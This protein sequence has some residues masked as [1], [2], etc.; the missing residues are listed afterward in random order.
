MEWKNIS[1]G[2]D[3]FLSDEHGCS[4]KVEGKKGH[5]FLFPS[6]CLFFPSKYRL[7]SLFSFFFLFFW[8][9]VSYLSSH[10][11]S[12]S[13]RLSDICLI[14]VSLPIS[15]QSSSFIS[16][17]QLG[18]KW[19]FTL[20]AGIILLSHFFLSVFSVFWDESWSS[21]CLLPPCCGSS[22]WEH[23]VFGFIWFG[24]KICRGWK[25]ESLASGLINTR[26]IW[27]RKPL[28]TKQVL[29]AP[30]HVSL[31]ERRC[32]RQKGMAVGDHRT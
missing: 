4:L 14:L 16:V 17:A 26:G 32:S 23:R 5:V 31:L 3:E 11:Y 30:R 20:F 18:G 6:Y 22:S 29:I 21:V 19:K 28:W 9:H 12:T 25:R 2:K 10:L 8:Y 1:V 7:I 13:I 27:V 24:L 15:L